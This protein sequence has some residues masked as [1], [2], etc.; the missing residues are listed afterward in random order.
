MTKWTTAPVVCG[1]LLLNLVL[2]LAIVGLLLHRPVLHYS[3]LPLGEDYQALNLEDLAMRFR[4]PETY[5]D[6]DGY[7]P[8]PMAAAE[9][10][11]RHALH[12]GL[13]KRDVEFLLGRPDVPGEGDIG[14]DSV[15]PPNEWEYGSLGGELVIEFKQGRVERIVQ[16]H[17]G[18]DLNKHDDVLLQ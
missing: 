1:L 3:N 7:T 17:D 12:K 10:I 6:K 8:R 18:D 14:L 16:T 15:G 13:E 4:Y 11:R 5:G 9:L 2:L